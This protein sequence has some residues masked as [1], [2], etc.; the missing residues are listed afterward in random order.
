MYVPDTGSCGVTFIL[1]WLTVPLTSQVPIKWMALESILNRTYTHQSDVWSYG[2]CFVFSSCCQRMFSPSL[3]P[4]LNP[5][6]ITDHIRCVK[7]LVPNPGVMLTVLEEEIFILSKTKCLSSMGDGEGGQLF[8][9]SSWD[10]APGS[11][12]TC[13]HFQKGEHWAT[14]CSFYD[15]GST[16]LHTSSLRWTISR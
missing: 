5:C 7:Q 16:H 4:R 13:Q 2:G 9:W 6:S 1:L 14:I 11:K 8:W 10:V 3:L 15:T 12:S